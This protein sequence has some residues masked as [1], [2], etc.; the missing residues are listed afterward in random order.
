[1]EKVG[2]ASSKIL[3]IVQFT[4]SPIRWALDTLEDKILRALGILIMS[5]TETT[6]YRWNTITSMEA[7]AVVSCWLFA[8]LCQLSC[9]QQASFLST[10]RPDNSYKIVVLPW[11]QSFNGMG[12]N[13]C[14]CRCWLLMLRYPKETYATTKWVILSLWVR[15]GSRKAWLFQI[16]SKMDLAE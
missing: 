12:L 3:R 7:S 15:Q 6:D 10:I 4:S 13:S 2:L 16:G 1:M 8:P 14:S 5:E 9:Y 11:S